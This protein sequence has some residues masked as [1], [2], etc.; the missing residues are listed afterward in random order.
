VFSTLDTADALTGTGAEAQAASRAMQESFVA[1]AR[2]GDP[3][4]PAIPHWPRYE[5]A[6]RSTM[7]FDARTRVED[8]PRAWQR[9][10]FARV[11]YVQPG[12]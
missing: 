10:L 1:F 8:D 2:T 7:V 3:N 4:N 5:L 12:T 9:A 6:A 11:P